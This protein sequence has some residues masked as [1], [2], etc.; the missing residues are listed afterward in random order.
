MS[1]CFWTVCDTFMAVTGDAR[2]HAVNTESKRNPLYSSQ[3][4]AS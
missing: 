2:D 3:K 1:L 4:A